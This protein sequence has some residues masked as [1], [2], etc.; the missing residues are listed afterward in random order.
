MVFHAI[1]SAPSV[2][3]SALS[4]CARRLR[5]DAP[6][7]GDPNEALGTLWYH[8]H[9]V[10]FTSQNVYKG[11]SVS[12]C[13]STTSTRRRDHGFRLPSGEFDV[14]LVVADKVF[15]EDGH[16][17]SI[18]QSRRH[19]GD[20]FVVNGKI[21]PFFEVHPA[22]IASASSTVALALLPIL[23]DGRERAEHTIPF[24]HIANDGN[25]LPKPVQVT[26]ARLGVANAPTS[27]SIFRSSPDDRSFSRT[28]S[29]RLMAGGQRAGSWRRDRGTP[30]CGSTWCFHGRRQSA[31]PATIAQLR[32]LP[33]LHQPM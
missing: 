3:R 33:R 1:S 2:L 31:D 5:L 11:L 28:A 25:L 21:Q 4:Q 27:S 20:R 14:P 16:S 13:C 15:D 7:N 8:D 10:D 30:C 18:V 12:T 24:W 17:S 23:S 22:G 19:L 6:P 26:S 9:R 32:A 29:S